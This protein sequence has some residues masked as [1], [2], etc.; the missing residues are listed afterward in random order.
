MRKRIAF[1]TVNVEKLYQTSLIEAMYQ[2]SAALCYDFIVLTHF[3][4][5]DNET[6][7]LKGDENI[8]TLIKQLS[9]DGA[10]IDLGSFYSRSLSKK[11]EDMLF[12]KGIPVIA[13]D[14]VSDRFESCLQ[15]NRENFQHL[16]EH[17]IR[18]HSFKKIYCLGGP[19]HVIH[20][21][22]RIEGYK[23][24]LA[25]NGIPFRQ[26]HVFY[27]DFWVDYAKSFAARI[28]NGEIERPQAIVCGND[29]MALQLCLS[30]AKNGINVPDDIAVGGYDG[31]PDV[32]S[33]H[34]SLTT[35]GNGF[36]EN[37][38]EAVCRIHK[39]ISGESPCNPIEVRPGVKV[40]ASC[41][42]KA[43]TS[44]DAVISDKMFARDMTMSIF[45]HSNYSS[46]MNNVKNMEECAIV[47]AQ[48]AYLLYPKSDFFLC[49]CSG[50]EENSG[51]VYTDKMF[52]RMKYCN[53][54]CDISQQEF[55]LDTMI[56]QQELS[57]QP[58][59]YIFT[60][61]H[62]LDRNFGYCVRRYS[63]SIVF[64]QYY[65]EFCQVAANTIERVRMLDYERYLNDKIQR[66]SER[67]ILTGLFSRK[68]LIS[69]TDSLASD[70]HYYGVLYCIEGAEQYRGQYGNE[71]VRQIIVSFAQAVNLSCARGELAARTGSEEFIIIGECD[72]YDFPEQLFINSL[73]S[74]LKMIE[75]QQNISISAMLRHLSVVTDS[76][77][78]P[79]DMIAQLEKKLEDMRS[80]S[81]E[82]TSEFLGKLRE[83]QYNI[84]EEP[85]LDWTAK[86]AASKIGIS[87]SYF[88]HLYR[89]F[90]NISF[91]AD[92][93]SARLALAERLLVNTSLNVSEIAEKCGYPDASHFMKLF[94]KKKGMTAS[95]Y[96]KIIKSEKA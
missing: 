39:L 42:C 27:G 7:H 19:E 29:Y 81:T 69:R 28:A 48:N 77:T 30:L 91:N 76:N 79:T 85:Q 32:S 3:V 59:A 47:L 89:L 80:S 45:M 67:D 70:R 12:E 53:G 4:N 25:E 90:L 37:G 49:L 65:G 94:R 87:V 83:L 54:R 60:P 14:Y 95:D 40:G 58:S 8:Y 11:L 78:A 93:I 64:E 50:D 20:T 96:R 10:I 62:Y 22:E 73:K 9:F 68:G 15:N 34:P 36:K 21:T 13:L 72:D 63:D 55:T 66:L 86:K 33:Y 2:Q 46:M 16:T 44:D 41:G 17:F 35:F 6:E 18:V 92:V 31:N 26:D 75:M 5:F 61:L 56:P 23:D 84:Y 82:N 1:I 43:D 24:A 38:I 88:Q 51:S 52:C 57:N 71:Y 74:N